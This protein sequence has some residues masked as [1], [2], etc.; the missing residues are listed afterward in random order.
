M[1]KDKSRKKLLSTNDE[2]V[3]FSAR[4]LVLASEHKKQLQIA[5]YCILSLII[6]F[7]AGNMYLKNR[8]TRAQNAYN[9]AYYALSGSISPDKKQE[10]Y[11]K[12]REDFGKV[13]TEYKMSGPAS[14]TLPQLAR[15]DFLEKKYEE[16]IIKY[17]DYLDKKPREPYYSYGILALSA[18]YEEK[19]DHDKA[20]AVLEKVSASEGYSKEQAMLGI[21]RIHRIKKDFV[22]SNE[23]LKDFIEKFPS[24]P[25]APA[26]KAAI[27]S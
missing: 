27:T 4:M 1:K 23:I 10:A 24:S 9:I 26:A 21:A 25:S 8:N 16:A 3:T 12:A 17:Q 22:K 2:F 19:G 20:I 18:C 15:I 6:L 5:G 7:V 14:V 11:A 13:L